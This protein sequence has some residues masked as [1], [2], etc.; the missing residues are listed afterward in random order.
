MYTYMPYKSSKYCV[1][2]ISSKHIISLSFV[3]GGGKAFFPLLPC[4]L[5]TRLTY[6]GIHKVCFML[7]HCHA[8]SE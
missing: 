6:T 8:L 1:Y 5:E 2:R 3:V 4:G 7:D